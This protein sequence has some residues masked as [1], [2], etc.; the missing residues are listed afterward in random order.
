[1]GALGDLRARILAHRAAM[2]FEGR[3]YWIPDT[4]PSASVHVVGEYFRQ[5][6]VRYA[7]RAGV[8]GAT[9]PGVPAPTD[10]AYKAILVRDREDRHDPNAVRVA[11]CVDEAETL[12]VGR[13]SHRD[14]RAYRP[15]FDML[16]SGGL[17]CDAT[18]I[19][20]GTHLRE[21]WTG[22]RLNLETPGEIVA[23]LYT[24]DYPISSAHEWRGQ[25]VS[26]AGAGRVRLRGVPLDR[27]AQVKLARMAGIAVDHHL[28]ERTRLVI[29]GDPRE[30]TPLI[31][32]A[33]DH[34]IDVI[35]EV[36][37]WPAVGVTTVALGNRSRWAQLAGAR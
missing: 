32:R 24:D 35:P 30:P 1:M 28:N 11:L 14:S 17:A 23:E 6:T 16:G 12:V 19:R 4:R 3:I 25:L 31:E 33:K 8:T 29:A 15:I 21:S 26:F 22:V 9:F 5:A 2:R 37:F 34:G 7:E 36:D 20:E 10:G 13:L 27:P 18:L